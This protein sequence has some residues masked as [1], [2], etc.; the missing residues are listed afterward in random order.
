MDTKL[1]KK[2][3][4]I[5]DKSSYFRNPEDIMSLVIMEVIDVYEAGPDETYAEIAETELAFNLEFGKR[6]NI[7]FI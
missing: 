5:G 4:N 1:K 6:L 3:I 7:E 2:M